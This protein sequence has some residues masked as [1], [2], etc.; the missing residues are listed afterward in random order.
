M[1][2]FSMLFLFSSLSKRLLC[3]NGFLEAKSQGTFVSWWVMST[4][5]RVRRIQV[6]RKRR[7]EVCSQ[8]AGT[9]ETSRRGFSE[10]GSLLGSLGGGRLLKLQSYNVDFSN[11]SRRKQIC[12]LT[13]C[14]YLSCYICCCF[15]LSSFL[16]LVSHMNIKMK[17]F[18]P[19]H[20]TRKNVSQLSETVYCAEISHLQCALY[21]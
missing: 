9:A 10:G 4:P 21:C 1:F 7:G 17:H 6:G 20:R 15:M 2:F 11:N 19:S 16:V 13:R 3:V 12:F 14:K 8:A 5:D 18:F